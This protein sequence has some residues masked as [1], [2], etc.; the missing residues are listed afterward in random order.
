MWSP[1]DVKVLK[2]SNYQGTGLSSTYGALRRGR[3][4]SAYRKGTKYQFCFGFERKKNFL[5]LF[6]SCNAFCLRVSLVSL[7]GLE[8]IFAYIWSY[9]IKLKLGFA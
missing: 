3:V 5:E 2:I 9:I 7:L 4:S 1:R 6:D 8:M